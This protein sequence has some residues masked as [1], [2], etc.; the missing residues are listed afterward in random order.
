MGRAI[1]ICAVCLV[2]W[3]GVSYGGMDADLQH[4]GVNPLSSGFRIS[5]D[6]PGREP[7]TSLVANREPFPWYPDPDSAV[8]RQA[9]VCQD[10]LTQ[11]A[12]SDSKDTIPSETLEPADAGIEGNG[13]PSAGSETGGIHYRPPLKRWARSE[14][15]MGGL[16]VGGF[17]LVYLLP[18]SVSKWEGDIWSDARHNFCRAWTEPPVWDKDD[19]VLNYVAHPWEGALYY[20]LLRSQGGG[21]LES[22]IFS[23]IQ[24][25]LWEYVFEAV[26][27][28]PS[29]QDLI[30]TPVV[31]APLGELIH[32]GTLKMKE[33]GFSLLEKIL[34]TILNPAFVVNNG[35]K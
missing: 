7:L 6:N 5:G 35:Y 33:N 30:V 9:R 4:E 15:M 34:V 18:D 28:Q 26:A 32:Y 23:A 8:P 31:G 2:L 1:G 14:L 20:D 3:P 22:F 27:E 29:I 13:D 25:C 21:I 24:S 10:L 11:I 17:L 16:V 12:Q 19:W